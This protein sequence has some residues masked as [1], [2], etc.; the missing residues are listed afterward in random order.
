MLVAAGIGGGIGDSDSSIIYHR[1]FSL[2]RSSILLC[3]IAINQ[4][5]SKNVCVCLSHIFI[6]CVHFALLSSASQNISITCTRLGYYFCFQF[7]VISFCFVFFNFLFFFLLSFLLIFR[8][9]SW[10]EFIYRQAN[11]YDFRSYSVD[12]CNDTYT[13]M[14][15][16]C[17]N[18]FIVLKIANLFAYISLL[19]RIIGCISTWH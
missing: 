2:S 1:F 18:I 4:I 8:F 15:L 12:L 7:F 3:H 14:Q 11:P 6:Y 19:S 13:R 10:S 5:K 16:F 9:Q 17:Y